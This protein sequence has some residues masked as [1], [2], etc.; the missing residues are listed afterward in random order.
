MQVID[1][2]GYSEKAIF[3]SEGLSASFGKD[4]ASQAVSGQTLTDRNN[5]GPWA[6]WG[7]DNRLPITMADHIENCGVLAAALDTKARIAVGKGIQAFTV[8]DIDNDGKENLKWVNDA[9]INEWM[10]ENGMYE[11]LLNFSYDKNAYGWRAGSF[12]LDTKREKINRI[13]RK[14]VYECRLQK[15]NTDGFIKSLYLCADWNTYSASF[16]KDQH[17]QVPAL[18]EGFEYADLVSRKGGYEF[19]FIDRHKRNGR[20]YYPS[21]QWYAAQEWVKL[22]RSVPSHKNTQFKRQITLQYVVT[23][24]SKFWETLY[25]NWATMEVAKKMEIVNKKYDEIDQWLSGSANAYKSLFCFAYVDPITGKEVSD[26]K[27]EAIDD[28]VKEGKMLP[29]SAAGNSEILFALNVNPSLVGAGQPGGPYSNNSGGSNVRESLMVQVMAMEDDR[30]MNNAMMDIV[31]RYNKWDKK[32]D[33][34]LVFRTQSGL[35]TTLDTG[36]STKPENL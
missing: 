21:A 22:V 1:N 4:G 18:K 11:K 24:S 2:I 36:K 6:F 5:P 19:A 16:N 10:D 17:V 12:I 23:I 14:D 13:T 33:K 26:I 31:K 35:L 8:E 20:Q 25:Q 27:I 32:F 29:D 34:P 7:S 15:K 9:E 3:L 28:K 30:K